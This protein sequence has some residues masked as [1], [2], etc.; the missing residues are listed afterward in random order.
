LVPLDAPALYFHPQVDGERVFRVHKNVLCASSSVLARMLDSGFQE[1][2]GMVRIGDTTDAVLGAVLSHIYGAEWNHGDMDAPLCLAVWELSHRLEVS[3]LEVLARDSA[4]TLAATT[5]AACLDLIAM[6]RKFD[7]ENNLAKAHMV[8]AEHICGVVKSSQ[9]AFLQ[10]SF[11][12][13]YAVVRFVPK[14]RSKITM[15]TLFSCMMDWVDASIDE[16]AAYVEKL[17]GQIDLSKVPAADLRLLATRNVANRSTILMEKF[18]LR[19]EQL[20]NVDVSKRVL[21]KGPL[22]DHGLTVAQVPLEASQFQ[23]TLSCSDDDCYDE[24]DS[25]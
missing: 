6:E 3:S 8:T 20:L 15:T 18:A 11:D 25:C 1:G 24:T 17:M 14:A 23:R 21:N 7:D 19:L 4:Y 9:E 12:D 13:L 22:V 2:N 16:R 5:H 10:L